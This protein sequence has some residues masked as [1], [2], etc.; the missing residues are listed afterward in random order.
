MSRRRKHF[1]ARLWSSLHLPG[2]GACAGSS[3]HACRAISPRSRAIATWHCGGT[4]LMDR[5]GS[6]AWS[7]WI[8]SNKRHVCLFHLYWAF[9]EVDSFGDL[10]VGGAGGVAGGLVV[11]CCSVGELILQQ[12]PVFGGEVGKSGYVF[13]PEWVEVVVAV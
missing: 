3:A 11:L 1:K 4:V 6:A 5:M 10:F 12:S 2:S 9:E 8:C 7:G 13:D